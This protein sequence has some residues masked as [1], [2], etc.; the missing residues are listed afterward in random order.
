M[1]RWHITAVWFG[2]VLLAAG[3]ASP[4]PALASSNTALIETEK[5]LVATVATVVQVDVPPV[6][7]PDARLDNVLPPLPVLPPVTVPDARLDNVLPP[8]PVLPPVTQL[9]P[10]LTQLVPAGLTNAAG[11]AQAPSSSPAQGPAL[12]QPTVSTPTDVGTGASRP[13]Q[14]T[15]PVETAVAGY[16]I[17]RVPSAAGVD[18]RKEAFRTAGQFRFPLAIAAAIIAF[19]VVQW[20][21]DRRDPKLAACPLSDVLLGFT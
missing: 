6:T 8:V 9:L 16:E 11:P 19:G 13:P 10:S 7:V 21:V 14:A 17:G 5:P 18:L 1:T 3:V 20:F 15:A 12:S 2:G 4:S